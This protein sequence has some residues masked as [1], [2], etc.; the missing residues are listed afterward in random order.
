MKILEQN[1]DYL[2]IRLASPENITTWCNHFLPNGEL[3]GQVLTSG[4]VDY[5][6]FKPET[7]GLFCEKIF[8]PIKN[9]E[10]QCGKYNDIQYNGIY[11]ELCGVLI[12]SPGSEINVPTLLAYRHRTVAENPLARH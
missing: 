2:T 8:G 6:T 7:D 5:Y 12:E 9:W 11:C 4:T 10:C 1:F 3:I